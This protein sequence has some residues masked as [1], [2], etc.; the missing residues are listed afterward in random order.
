MAQLAGVPEPRAP[1]NPDSPPPL[2]VTRSFRPF[3]A[4]IEVEHLVHLQAQSRASTLGGAEGPAGEASGGLARKTMS[5]Q[6]IES[7]RQLACGFIERVAGRLGFPR[8]TTAT[9]QKLYHRFHLHFPLS[10]FAYQDVSLSAL[11]VAAKLEDTLKKLRDIQI[12]A[13]QVQNMMDGGSGVGEGDPNTQEAHRPH[14]I[15]IE[16]LILQTIC[17]NFNLNRPLDSSPSSP[18]LPSDTDSLLALATLSP[19]TSAAT[20]RDAF[21]HLFRLSSALPSVPPALVRSSSASTVD[22]MHKS[23]IYAAFLLLTDLHR[24]L[25]PLSYPPHTCAAACIW[26]AGFILAIPAAR[27]EAENGSKNEIGEKDEVVWDEDV[28]QGWASSCET[29]EDDIDDIAQTLLNLLISLCPPSP[30]AASATANGLSVPLNTSP[31]FSPVSPAEPSQ[32]SSSAGGSIPVATSERDR[33]LLQT[34]VPNVFSHPDLLGQ[35]IS[36]NDLMGIKIQLRRARAAAA[37]LA[38][39]KRDREEAISAVEQGDDVT[40]HRSK[41]WQGLSDGLAEVGR[42][43]DERDQKDRLRVEEKAEKEREKS[44]NDANAVGGTA[45]GRRG[46]TE[47]ERERE[48]RERRERGKPGSVRYRF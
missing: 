43:R 1:R 48:R 47:E 6:R 26:T 44:E 17:F 14:L 13:W 20:S 12:A 25:A 10:D 8:R 2:A 37:A 39:G 31:L 27:Q 29:L 7:L 28:L 22:E 35:P 9:A 38:N 24:T 18:T 30:T 36:A 40:L 21:T 5:D 11:L 34:G 3:Y 23:L 46:K 41:R 33:H 16:R 4:P 42:I 19:S 15:G 45:G 32:T